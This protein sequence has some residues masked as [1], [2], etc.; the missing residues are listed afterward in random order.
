MLNTINI[1]SLTFWSSIYVCEEHIHGLRMG[2]GIL[3]Y[4][5][6]IGG[7]PMVRRGPCRGGRG[8]GRIFLLLPL[9]MSKYFLCFTKKKN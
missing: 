7:V 9:I 4:K 3:Q 8:R 5:G 2:G 1:L 6:H